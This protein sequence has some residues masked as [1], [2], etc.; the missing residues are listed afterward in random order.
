M[1]AFQ[2]LVVSTRDT[3]RSAMA[4]HIFRARLGPLR[5]IGVASAGT[6]VAT[7]APMPPG[8]LALMAHRGVRT[9]SGHVSRP[10]TPDLAR[11]ADV[12]LT[13]TR[14]HRR[15]VAQLSPEA[16]RST[17]T[18]VEFARVAEIVTD[19]DLIA[20][21][22]ELAY[23][24]PAPADG[25]GWLRAAVLVAEGLRGLASPPR[26]AALDIDEADRTRRGDYQRV[27]AQVAPAVEAAAD[28][29]D[30]A[31]SLAASRPGE[32]QASA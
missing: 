21:G 16:S 14:W 31:A 3:V 9:A 23:P 32:A 27:E 25:E 2:I 7:G 6:G 17:F 22:A 24:H 19:A 13:A 8:A 26:F 5:G 1:S 18:L 4:E 15:T 11:H 29:F 10:L 28:L 20:A 30:R 12:V